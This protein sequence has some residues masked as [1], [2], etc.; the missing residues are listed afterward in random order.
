LFVCSGN[1]DSGVLVANKVDVWGWKIFTDKD[2]PGVAGL[3]VPLKAVV[4]LVV[5]ESHA[6]LCSESVSPQASVGLRN[7][8]WSSAAPVVVESVGNLVSWRHHLD[9]GS[10]EPTVDLQGLEAGLITAF[11]FLV[12]EPSGS[13]NVLDA[14]GPHE[15]V[16]KVLLGL[17]LEAHHVHAHLTAI[18]PAG[19]PVPPGVPQSRLTAGPRHPVALSSEGKVTRLALPGSALLGVWKAD[20]AVATRVDLA[21]SRISGVGRSGSEAIVIVGWPGDWSG[22]KPVVI[23][24]VVHNPGCSPAPWGCWWGWKPVV[25]AELRLGHRQS[26]EGRQGH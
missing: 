3:I 8:I 12:A 26:H 22:D 4:E 15:L 11:D 7:A 17:G 2:P 6:S 14:A 10:P 16:D 21:A 23:V 20:S 25:V 13:V 5:E 9:G 24:V 19:E 18:V 1:V